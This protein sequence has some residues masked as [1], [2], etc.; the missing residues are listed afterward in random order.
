[1]SENISLGSGVCSYTVEMNNL[2]N[3]TEPEL[4]SEW[5]G[6]ASCE[7]CGEPYEIESD[8]GANEDMVGLCF[9]CAEEIAYVVERATLLAEGEQARAFLREVNNAQAQART[10]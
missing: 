3:N 7:G 5:Q 6:C 2:T 9:S 1:L 8:I 4:D 10:S